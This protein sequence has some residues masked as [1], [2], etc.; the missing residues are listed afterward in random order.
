MTTIQSLA[1]ELHRHLQPS[2]ASGLPLSHVH[3]LLAA[4]CG[5]GSWAAMNSQGLLT[6]G[7]AVGQML[8]AK[9]ADISGRAVQ[10][11]YNATDGLALGDAL[12]QQVLRRSVRWIT[13]TNLE[14]LLQPHLGPQPADGEYADDDNWELDDELE[15]EMEHEGTSGPVP[16]LLRSSLLLNSLAARA[17]KRPEL[18]LWLAAIYRCR[19]PSAYLW[20]QQQAGELL[21]VTE[22]AF[23]AQYIAL[24][25]QH[26]AYRS[27][28]RAAAEAGLPSA[29]LEWAE[30]FEDRSYLHVFR[31][32]GTPA[33]LVRVAALTMNPTERT[34]LLKRAAVQ[35]HPAA[36]RQLAASGDPDATRALAE[37]GDRECLI[38]LASVA[39][40]VGDVEQAWCWQFVAQHHGLD[41]TDSNAEAFHEGGLYANEPY[42][43]D[44]GGAPV[45]SRGRISAAVR[46]FGPSEGPGTCACGSDHRCSTPVG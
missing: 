9:V 36:L 38:K 23:V 42:D 4:C 30:V 35:L 31:S 46:D 29:A 14:K 24:K 10:L 2:V 21:N 32:L 5:L 12:R 43:D 45:R 11:G 8:P 20:E 19:V 26:E 25:P 1:F 34:Q 40:G 18:H 44:Q 22:Q 27:H 41:L 15:E 13:W 17:G 28:L 3:E 7:E 33:Q 6:D 39:L 16:A 37:R